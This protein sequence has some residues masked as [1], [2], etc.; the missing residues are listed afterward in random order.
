MSFRMR[1]PD[2]RV[3]PG[4]NYSKDGTVPFAVLT[5]FKFA[6]AVLTRFYV[7]LPIGIGVLGAVPSLVLRTGPNHPKTGTA[8]P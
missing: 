4:P 8:T 5:R 6:C 1:R 2:L 7:M 3:G